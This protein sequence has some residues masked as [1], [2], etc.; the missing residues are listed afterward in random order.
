MGFLD[1]FADELV[2]TAAAPE[3]ALH[4][5]ARRLPGL[6]AVG[7]GGAALGYTFGRRKGER[8]GVQ[9]GVAVTGDVAR[10]AYRA[11]VERGAEQMRDAVL[12]AG[13]ASSGEG[14]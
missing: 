11:G 2:K 13:G 9:E 12:Q 1:A 6:A 14:Q 8:Q 3:G 10:R 4:S 7:G 5:L